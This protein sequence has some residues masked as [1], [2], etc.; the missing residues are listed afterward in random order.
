[1]TE[2]AVIGESMKSFFLIEPGVDN[3]IEC[4]TSLSNFVKAFRFASYLVI[5]KAAVCS[6]LS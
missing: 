2:H 3:S 4:G 1:M 6:V 5:F